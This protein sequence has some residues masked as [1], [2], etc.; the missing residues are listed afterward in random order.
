MFGRKA[1]R[2]HI[3]YSLPFVLGEFFIDPADLL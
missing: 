2:Y 3:G 1:R